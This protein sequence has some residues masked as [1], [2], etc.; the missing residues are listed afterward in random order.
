MSNNDWMTEELSSKYFEKNLK[1]FKKYFEKIFAKFLKKYFWRLAGAKLDNLCREQEP[2]LISLFTEVRA[3]AELDNSVTFEP[4][5]LQK[6]QST[7]NGTT[8]HQKPIY[9]IRKT[10]YT[11]VHL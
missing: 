5:E 2:S 4:F 10:N 8:L 7:K 9:I 1:T 6:W 3:G 11:V